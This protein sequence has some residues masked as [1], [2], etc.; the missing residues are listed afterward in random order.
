MNYF[1]AAVMLLNFVL[2]MSFSLQLM[3]SGQ[4]RYMEDRLCAFA[5]GA[6]A[7]WSFGFGILYLVPKLEYAYY[8]RLIGMVGVFLFLISAQV[9]ICY[10]STIALWVRRI[11]NFF[12]SLGI[13]LYFLVIRPDLTVFYYKN[14]YMTYSFLPGI[15]N[16]LYTGYSVIV[17]INMLLVSLYMVRY[18]KKKRVRAYGKQFLIVEAMIVI[19][20]VLDTVFPLLG[21]SAIPGSSIMQFWGMVILFRANQ[22][23]QKTHV[24]IGNM[25]EFIYSSLATPVLIYNSEYELQVVNDAAIQ[26]LDMEEDPIGKMQYKMNSLFALNEDTFFDFEEESKK[27]D[28]TCLRNQVYCS[29]SVSKIKDTYGDVIGYI[30]ILADLS[31]RMKTLQK[32]EEAKIAADAANREKSVFLAN[33]SHEIR[34]P[35]NAIIGFS[36]L[37]LKEEISEQAKDYVADIR[38]SSLNLLAIINDILD[39]S[40]IESGKVELVCDNYDTAPLF[41]EIYLIVNVQAEK[42]GLDF[43]MNIAPDFP[44]ELY[45]DKIR[46]RQVLINLLNNAVK[47]TQTGE[48]VFDARVKR[49]EAEEG[50]NQSK[51]QNGQIIGVEF[52]VRDTGLGIKEEDLEKIFESF[53]Q[54]DYKNHSNIEGTGLGLPITKRL[55]EM[56]GG[57]ISVD[58]IYGSGTTFIAQIEQKVVNAT[59]LDRSYKVETTSV[60]EYSLGSMKLHSVDILVVDDN[61]VNLKV[62][63]KSLAYY[64]IQVDV[65]TSG[66]EAIQRCMEKM[67]DIVFMDQMMPGMDGIEAMQKIRT[68]NEHYAMNGQG[69]IVVLTANAVNGVKEE[70]LQ[71]GFDAY[72]GK[73]INYADMEEVFVQFLNP[74]CIT[75]DKE[76]GEDAIQ[77]AISVEMIASDL[78]SIQVEKGI[79]NCGGH[80]EDFLEILQAVRTSVQQNINDLTKYKEAQDWENYAIVA[81][82]IKGA[83]L[84]IGALS[85]GEQAKKLEF[86]GKKKQGDV[87]DLLHEEFV[88][89]Y[90]NLENE[91]SAFLKK[92]NYPVSEEESQM[93][94]ALFYREL[95]LAYQQ[96]DFATAS[97]ILREYESLAGTQ[98]SET[99]Y[100]QL[101]VYHENMDMD[102]LLQ[103]LEEQM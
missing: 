87:V 51:L 12:A 14:G 101:K 74:D 21:L 96:F 30:I 73:P 81:H 79:Y 62:I 78:P 58:S 67:Y 25:S 28:S 8:C 88:N 43:V 52:Q 68:L 76:E 49:L 93:D 16:N 38:M 13:V 46:V 86:A 71:E 97:E 61:T 26:F 35:M 45:G 44:S 53:T 7:I 32:L 24:S 20:M 34:T 63:D 80:M 95:Y 66:L 18:A 9:L 10:L 36:E 91:I 72:L 85:I 92:S 65:A 69:K 39:I 19:G 5:S 90:K 103:I 77:G 47:Y 98:I 4:V 89:L 70:L 56:M 102:E 59:P 2:A 100:H 23:F 31:E 11:I 15:I 6:S 29:I 60:G 3:F 27:M 84:N 55:V 50:E 99:L 83:L 64:G 82:A 37:V 40:K 41:N 94:A 17:A 22:A 1:F 42:K 48:V 57:E 54:S 33:M 75:Y